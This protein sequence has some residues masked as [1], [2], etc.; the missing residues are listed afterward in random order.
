MLLLCIIYCICLYYSTAFCYF[1]RPFKVY[2]N[3][4]T[5]TKKKKVTLNYWET[6][7]LSFAFFDLQGHYCFKAQ[8][9]HDPHVISKL[10]MFTFTNLASGFSFILKN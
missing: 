10:S 5:Q 3:K 6:F 9:I 8:L 4:C 7:L 1:L 2:K